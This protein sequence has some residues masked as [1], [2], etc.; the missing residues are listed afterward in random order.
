LN[1]IEKNGIKFWTCAGC[2]STYK[3]KDFLFEVKIGFPVS[4]GEPV[5]RDGLAGICGDCAISWIGRRD[6]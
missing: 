3:E 5:F 4:N 6:I 2:G 1:I